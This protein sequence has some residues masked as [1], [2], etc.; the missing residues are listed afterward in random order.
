MGGGAFRPLPP[1][2][3]RPTAAK[4]ALVTAAEVANRLQAAWCC[5]SSTVIKARC[6]T[7][8]R[9]AALHGQL[10][11]LPSVALVPHS[12]HQDREKKNYTAAV[13]LCLPA[14]PPHHLLPASAPVISSSASHHLSFLCASFVG[15]PLLIHTLARRYIY[16][17]LINSP[18]P[19]DSPR[20]RPF[21]YESV[22]RYLFFLLPAVAKTPY[23]L[24]VACREPAPST[25]DDDASA[26]TPAT[27]L[28]FAFFLARLKPHPFCFRAPGPVCDDISSIHKNDAKTASRCGSRNLAPAATVTPSH[29]LS[30][31]FALPTA[32]GRDAIVSAPQPGLCQRPRTHAQLHGI[33]F[34][35]TSPL[36]PLAAAPAQ[37]PHIYTRLPC[38]C[39]DGAV[40]GCRPRLGRSHSLYQLSRRKVHRRQKATMGTRIRRRQIRHHRP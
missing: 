11:I 14:S 36:D 34:D 23:V 8:L 40:T 6:L 20:H 16:F 37:Q 10:F 24:T 22:A 31:F 32:T 35:T 29:N 13:S 38:L 33:D 39:V 9:L 18:P 17:S 28:S 27:N 5:L 12:H 2:W 4:L 15:I 1:R 21:D 3:R 26:L 19:S 25:P 30:T 7:V